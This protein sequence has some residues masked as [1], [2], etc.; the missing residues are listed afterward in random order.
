M[1]KNI[2]Q[3]SPFEAKPLIKE[4]FNHKNYCKYLVYN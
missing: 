1:K 3:L 2:L 4:Y